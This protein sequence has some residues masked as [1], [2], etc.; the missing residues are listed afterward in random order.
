MTAC[1]FCIDLM[2]WGYCEYQ[3]IWD[4]PLADGDLLCER[5]MGNSHNP[6]AMALK[7]VVDG[8]PAASCWAC[9]WEISSNKFI[10][11][12]LFMW[13][14]NHRCVKIWMVKICQIFGCSSILPNFLSIRYVT[15]IGMYIVCMNQCSVLVRFYRLNRY[16]NFTQKNFP[17]KLFPILDIYRHEVSAFIFLL[18]CMG[19]INLH[20]YSVSAVRLAF[21]NRFH[22]T[23]YFAL[24]SESNFT[25]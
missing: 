13:D 14:F 18:P 24:S 17:K 21:S 20:K 2:V 12:S 3:S 1:T 25:L 10:R 4:I 19:F 5:K 11:Y 16:R 22:S 15:F 9:A 8:I 23:R 7:K 6:Q